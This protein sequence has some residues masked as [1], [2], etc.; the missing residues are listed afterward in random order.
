MQVSAAA[1]ALMR[2]Y[3]RIYFACHTRHIRDPATDR[4]LSSH[5]VSVLD[6]LDTVEPTLVKDLAAHMGVTPST[7]S[8]T[9]DRLEAGGYVRRR[10][11]S[12]DS[13]KVGVLLT[14]AGERVRQASSVLDESLVESLFRQLS[15]ADRERGVE[16]LRLLADA[17]GRMSRDVRSGAW[18]S[19][20]SRT[21]STSS[22]K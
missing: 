6:H 9:L 22:R 15:P 5:Q 8:L 10:R 21:T 14:V 1:A 20:P 13:R 18:K 16:A 3:P 17:A 7:M 19:S 4:T 2:L 11:D 12:K